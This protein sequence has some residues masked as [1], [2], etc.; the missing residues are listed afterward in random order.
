VIAGVATSVPEPPPGWRRVVAVGNPCGYA[1]FMTGR[2]AR[3]INRS[4]SREPDHLFALERMRRFTRLL[5]GRRVSMATANVVMRAVPVP[6]G[7]HV[8]EMSYLPPAF[9]AGAAVSLLS[10]LILIG[11]F[12]ALRGKLFAKREGALSPKGQSPSS[13]RKKA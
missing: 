1:N 13:T 4:Q 5:Y 8:V 12:L 10:V 6:A 7:K 2:R 3:D 9:V 11:I